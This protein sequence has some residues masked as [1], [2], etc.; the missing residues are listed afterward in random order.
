MIFIHLLSVNKTNSD[1]LSQ[2]F[3]YEILNWHY[4]CTFLTSGNS[5]RLR[6]NYDRSQIFTGFGK[7]A[8]FW[9]EP[10]SGATLVYNST[11]KAWSYNLSLS[12][13]YKY[14][15][16]NILQ[17]LTRVDTVTSCRLVTHDQRYR[18]IILANLVK[19]CRRLRD[20]NTETDILC[21]VNKKWSV[22]AMAPSSE[23]FLHS[24]LI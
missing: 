12:N 4:L 8:G 11:T 24:D 10:D 14:T 9:P 2:E 23:T 13:R 3:S 6:R 21:D 18:G 22:T 5:I 1:D 19:T 15:V 20:L 7:N 16:S 17:L